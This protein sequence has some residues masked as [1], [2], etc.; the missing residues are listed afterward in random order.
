[1]R[2]FKKKKKYYSISKQNEDGRKMGKN[3][4]QIT[5]KLKEFM[6]KF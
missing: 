6:R 5:R 2:M 4:P 3:N 1:M